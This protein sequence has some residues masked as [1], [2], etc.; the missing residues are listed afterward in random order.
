MCQDMSLSNPTVATSPAAPTDTTL[1]NPSLEGADTSLSN[2]NLSPSDTS[3]SNPNLGQGRGSEG[4]SPTGQDT[5]LSNPNLGGSG[6]TSLSNNNIGRGGI[7]PVAPSGGRVQPLTED[8]PLCQ[9]TRSGCKCKSQWLFSLGGAAIYKGCS[10]PTEDRNGLWC[11]IDQSSCDVTSLNLQILLDQ[12]REP[13]DWFGTVEYADYCNQGCPQQSMS[14]V[15]CT[16]TVNGCECKR[17]WTYSTPV[18]VGTFEGCVNVDN[19]GGGKWCKVDED[20]CPLS[21]ISKLGIFADTGEYFDF[22]QCEGSPP[23][24]APPGECETDNGCVCLSEWTFQSYSGYDCDNPDQ[25]EEGPW[26]VVSLDGPDDECTPVGSLSI[27]G[28][29]FQKYWDYCKC[30]NSTDLGNS[31]G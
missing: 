2:P 27:E 16:T 14:K 3:L 30:T 28:Q 23:P 6:D 20:S 8:N 17:L 1:S 22:C 29:S 24:Q 7:A 31:G 25:W 11:V 12:A 26:C 5:S 13:I 9:V 10:N 19:D 21:A 18:G 15:D 4:D